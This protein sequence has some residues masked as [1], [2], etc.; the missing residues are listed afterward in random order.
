MKFGTRMPLFLCLITVHGRHDKE[1]K[2]ARGSTVTA[3]SPSSGALYILNW[4][5]LGAPAP[6]GYILFTR[7]KE[8]QYKIIV[9]T[10]K[11]EWTT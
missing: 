11:H 7:S 1:L 8:L 5:A 4:D 3:D 10:H 9:I 2:E 6:T